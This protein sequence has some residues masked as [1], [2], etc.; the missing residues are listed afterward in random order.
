MLWCPP[1]QNLAISS[2][3]NYANLGCVFFLKSGNGFLNPKTN[4]GF[5]RRNP[6]NVLS[7]QNIQTRGGSSGSN[8]MRNFQS[9]DPSAFF[10]PERIHKKCIWQAVF[11]LERIARNRELKEGSAPHVFPLTLS[12]I[13]NPFTD[14]PKKKHTL[15]ER[16]RLSLDNLVNWLEQNTDYSACSH[17]VI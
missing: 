9:R 14:S 3:Y 17:V 13:T 16:T 15:S 4:F 7:I 10:W 1:G 6:K 8:L 5:F 12:E 2:R 11:L